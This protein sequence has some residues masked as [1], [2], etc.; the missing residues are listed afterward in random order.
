MYL[1]R[2]VDD[3]GEVLDLVVQTGRDTQVALRLLKRLLRNRPLVPEAIVADG[4]AS[5]SAA[6]E[7]LGP[8]HLPRPGRLRESNRRRARTSRS[9]GESG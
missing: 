1:W 5:C 6:L 3:E 2:A 4:L 7:E 8:L 9:V